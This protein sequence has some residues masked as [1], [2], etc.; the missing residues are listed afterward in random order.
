MAGRR[1][2]RDN[3]HLGRSPRR[4]KP[5]GRTR[6]ACDRASPPRRRDRRNRPLPRREEGTRRRSLRRAG[7]QLLNDTGRRLLTVVGELAQLAGW[8]ASDAG[9]YVE[10]QRIYLSGVT[11]ARAADE[12]VLAGQLLS[13]LSYQAANVADPADAALLARSAVTGA[14]A[15]TPTFARCSSNALHGPVRA[16]VTVTPPD[17]RSMRSTMLIPIGHPESKNRSGS[18]GS[19]GK[20]SMSWLVVA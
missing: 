11:A 15:G 2:P 6:T 10:A 7:G 12:P 9:Q 3:A 14:E 20:R 13:S 19:T 18:T 5:R 17:E 1:H 8:V 16:L 4:H